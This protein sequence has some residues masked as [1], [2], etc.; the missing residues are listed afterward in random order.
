MIPS[1]EERTETSMQKEEKTNDGKIYKQIKR[2]FCKQGN[3]NFFYTD[4]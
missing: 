1:D 4:F 3:K 2:L